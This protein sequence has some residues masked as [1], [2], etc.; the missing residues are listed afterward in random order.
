MPHLHLPADHT[1]TDVA[2][3]ARV[4]ERVGSADLYV[5]WSHEHGQAA[6]EVEAVT[7]AERPRSPFAELA[8]AL[9]A[10]F[11]ALWRAVFTRPHPTTEPDPAADPERRTAPR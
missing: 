2:L 8:V 4:A 3:A 1:D 6:P 9:A 10:A 7:G 11:A 5:A